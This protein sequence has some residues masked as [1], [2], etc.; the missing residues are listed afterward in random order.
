MV[1]ALC[2]V[3]QTLKLPNSGVVSLGVCVEG[4]ALMLSGG[5]PTLFAK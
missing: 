1:G 2:F 4:L 5:S 3:G